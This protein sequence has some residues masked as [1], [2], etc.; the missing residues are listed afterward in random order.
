[1]IQIFNV[2]QTF[3]SNLTKM[4]IVLETKVKGYKYFEST[5]KKIIEKL[6]QEIFYVFETKPSL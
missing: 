6:I 3:C 1:M 2:F 5:F 4:F